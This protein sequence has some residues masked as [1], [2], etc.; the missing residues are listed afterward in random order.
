MPARVS[1][2]S[3]HVSWGRSHSMLHAELRTT[4]DHYQYKNAVCYVQNDVT[5]VFSVQLFFSNRLC[6]FRLWTLNILFNAKLSAHT[7][8]NSFVWT[9]LFR[10][11]L[12]PGSVGSCVYPVVDVVTDFI[13][14]YKFLLC[15]VIIWWLV[16]SCDFCHPQKENLLHI[17]LKC[18][19]I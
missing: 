6:S 9:K 13:I 7:F 17:S 16:C 18:A 10:N 5:V 14:Q 12:I 1:S 11:S 15:S 8:W 3:L 4:Q 19:S 2:S